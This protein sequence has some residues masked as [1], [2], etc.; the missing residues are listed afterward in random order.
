MILGMAKSIYGAAYGHAVSAMIVGRKQ[1]D[2]Y[3]E[4]EKTPEEEA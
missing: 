3:A 2:R 1:M 4:H